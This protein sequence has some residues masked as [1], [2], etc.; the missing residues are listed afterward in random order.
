MNQYERFDVDNVGEGITDIRIVAAAPALPSRLYVIAAD[1]DMLRALRW[2]E[3]GGITVEDVFTD[4][5][6][7]SLVPVVEEGSVRLALA[8]RGG[9]H[10]TLLEPDP[11]GGEAELIDRL[12][13]L[14]EPDRIQS[15][16]FFGSGRNDLV[17]RSDFSEEITVLQALGGFAFAPGDSIRIGDGANDFTFFIDPEDRPFLASINRNSSRLTLLS[18]LSGGLLIPT[19]DF[20]AGTGPVSIASGL[21]D[22]DS[23][24]DVVIA[25]RD[26]Q[27]VLV[28]QTR[29]QARIQTRLDLPVE[30]EP[31]VVRTDDLTLDGRDDIVIGFAEGER[32]SMVVE[33][34][35]NQ[36]VSFDT[37]IP[38][39][40][41]AVG[42]LNGDGVPDFAA[43]S[44][45]RSTVTVYVSTGATRV[46][47]WPL[48]D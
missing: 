45:A 30:D 40:R 33:Q 25:D 14:I 18:I 1:E 43:A 27:R 26:G 47:Y 46:G 34:R 37:A 11:D 35:W 2:V 32:V 16:D 9:P 28:W 7:V 29:Q 13:L 23:H 5:D 21:V 19:G 31:A 42:D 41:I 8:S 24:P 12:P 15:F 22:E 10:V 6:P 38:S 48:F 20:S 36:P 39:E 17:L 3:G 44:S 4:D